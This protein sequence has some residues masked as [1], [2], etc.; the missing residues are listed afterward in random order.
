MRRHW[1]AAVFVFSLLLLPLATASHAQG[2]QDDE[3]VDGWYRPVPKADPKA[4]PGPAPMH[5]V[6]GTWEPAN[7]WRNG[8]QASGAYNYPMDGK[9]FVPYTPAGEAAWKEHKY[10]DGFGSYPLEEVNDPFEMCDPIGFPR[11]SLHD[12]RALEILQTP[13][14]SIMIYENDQVWR[15]IWTDGREFP[16]IVEPRWY[17]YSTGKW[18][19]P[20]T[21]VIQTEGM[22]P[23]TW[24]DNTGRP[25][26]KDLK[27]EETFHRANHDVTE[28]TLTINDPAY[29]SKPWNALDKYPMRL[30]SDSFDV[31]EMVCSES[32]AAEYNKNIGDQAAAPKAG[33]KK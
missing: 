9:H 19:D 6:S 26:T 29:Y 11:V 8:V 31:R 27:V 14:K 10:G 21:F 24:I 22:D 15:T 12:L 23:R 33:D 5:D 1:I 32:E 13:K 7:G 30:Q 17:G 18:T 28:Y 16:K 20:T 4:K 3:H 25:H 2:E